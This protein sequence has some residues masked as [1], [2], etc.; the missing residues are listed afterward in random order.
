MS[1]LY[2]A[3]WYRFNEPGCF[4]WA[5]ALDNGRIVVERDWKF[6]HKPVA[7][8][9]HEI[10]IRSN[11]LDGRFKAIYAEPEMFPKAASETRRAIEAETPSQ[12]FARYGLSMT[13]A[14]GNVIHGWSRLHD[15]L[16]DAP[17]GQP[18]LIIDKAGCPSLARTLRTLVQRKT[19]PDDC[20]GELYAAHALRILLSA[21]PSPLTLKPPKPAYPWGTIGW[22]RQHQDRLQSTSRR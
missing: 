6:I 16:R 10:L 21:R 13:P 7:V 11:E 22:L 4:L 15:Y 5:R 8:A 2:G 19:D 12:I 1:G 20:E 18:W 17:D 3:C 14:G 9:A